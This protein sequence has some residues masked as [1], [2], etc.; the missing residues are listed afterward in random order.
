MQPA[1]TST[2]TLFLVFKTS[3]LSY[4]TRHYNVLY[5]P[6]YAADAASDVTSFSLNCVHDPELAD[7][8]EAIV[9]M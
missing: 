8:P 3:E 6:V 2:C 5:V 1:C 7:N 4:T 9:S